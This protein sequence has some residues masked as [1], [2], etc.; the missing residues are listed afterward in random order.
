MC[1]LAVEVEGVRV[2]GIR[3]DDADVW[4]KGYI[5]MLGVVSLPH[6]WGHDKEGTHLTVV[7]VELQA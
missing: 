5:M 7:P 2:T 3:P 1:G 4:N 6:G